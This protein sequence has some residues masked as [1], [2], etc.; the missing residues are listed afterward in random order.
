M[1]FVSRGRRTHRRAGEQVIYSLAPDAPFVPFTT[2]RYVDYCMTCP[3]TMLD[4]LWNL[5]APYKVTAALLVLTCLGHAVVCSRKE[6]CK[7]AP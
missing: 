2:I 4:L 5:D 3:I 6:P 7:R 1:T